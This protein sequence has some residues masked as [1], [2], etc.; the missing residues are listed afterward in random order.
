[1]RKKE[2]MKADQSLTLPERSEIVRG[3]SNLESKFMF[4]TSWYAG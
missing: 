3:V 2:A 1:M 4:L